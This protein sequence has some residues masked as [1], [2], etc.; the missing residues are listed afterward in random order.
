MDDHDEPLISEGNH[1][2]IEAF[3][4]NDLHLSGNELIIYAVIYGFSQDGKS[5][6]YGSR[7]YLAE[8]CQTSEK[9]VSNNLKKLLDKGLIAK[10]Q[11]RVRCC[12]INNYRAVKPYKQDGCNSKGEESSARGKNVPP[13]REESS[14]YKGEESS[15]NTIGIDI[16]SKNDSHIKGLCKEVLD[17]LNDKTGK[18][19]RLVKKNVTL[20]GA[21]LN[22]GF[23]VEVMKRAIDTKCSQWLNDP[24]M[25]RYLR[26]ETLF[27]NKL[28]GYVNESKPKPSYD[29]SQYSLEH[30]NVEYRGEDSGT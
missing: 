19:F 22:E 14:P 11:K 30:F 8:W 21:R 15:P 17:Y 13:K 24:N 3:M 20:I 12:T 2:S 18:H 28:D 6:F 9:T 1:I 4:V 7:K 23:T 5:W 25:D 29:T 16:P 26:P 27:G 10:R